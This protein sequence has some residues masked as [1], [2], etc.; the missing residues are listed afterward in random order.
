MPRSS[1]FYIIII[2]PYSIKI[3]KLSLMVRGKLIDI[4]FNIMTNIDQFYVNFSILHFRW[5][6]DWRVRIT[7]MKGAK[8]CTAQFPSTWCCSFLTMSN[9]HNIDRNTLLDFLLL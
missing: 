7:P 6:F 1:D 4:Y 8:V 5:F 2:V 3:L 9:I